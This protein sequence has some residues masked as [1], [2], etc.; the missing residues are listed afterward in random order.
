MSVKKF[1]I[2]LDGVPHEVEVEE[3]GGGPTPVVP[4]S[5][6]A[7]AAPA[8]APVAPRP[9]TPA[10]T[11]AETMTAP[12]PGNIN[13]VAVTAGQTV[14]AGQTLLV[15]EAMKMENEIVAPRDCVVASVA[16]SKGDSVNAGDLLVTLQ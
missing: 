1:R 4:A 9:V 5:P 16:V 10:P 6:A 7:S 12:M 15:L 13:E 11:G 2:I 14:R 3:L 8:P